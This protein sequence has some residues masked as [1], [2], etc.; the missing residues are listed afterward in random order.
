MAQRL[1]FQ[2]ANFATDFA[3][4]LSSKRETDKGVQDIV[5]KIID[6]IRHEGDAALLDLTAKFDNL[7]VGK[8]ADLSV[9]REELTSALAS[10]DHKLRSALELA[11]SRIRGFH[12]KQ[13][14]QETPLASC[15]EQLL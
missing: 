7:H 2:S 10:L 4:L 15:R 14:P 13:L 9:S 11:A 6:S 3:V 1:D 12:Q 5:S 8:V